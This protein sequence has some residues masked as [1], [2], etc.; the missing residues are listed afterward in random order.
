[1][2]S[3]VTSLVLAYLFIY[4][5]GWKLRS[6]HKP[7]LLTLLFRC[8]L[9]VA[10]QWFVVIAMYVDPLARDVIDIL[11]MAYIPVSNP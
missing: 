4:F 10:L 3:A 8:T 5:Y 1:M 9:D 6:P 11:V 2:Q 7:N